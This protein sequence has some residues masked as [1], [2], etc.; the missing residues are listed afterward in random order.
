M[1][2]LEKTIYS[3]YHE[4]IINFKLYSFRKDKNPLRKDI[5]LFDFIKKNDLNDANYNLFF[6]QL[7]TETTN[8]N[9]LDRLKSRLLKEIDNSLIQFHFH[10]SQSQYIYNE[11][12]LYKI[13]SQRN[14]LDL[15][16][17]HLKKAETK[18]IESYDYS[19]LDIIY[20]EFI[21]VSIQYGAIE[22]AIYISKRN[23][24]NVILNDLRALD[25]ALALIIFD[26]KT[27]QNF[28]SINFQ[29]S[30]ALNKAIQQLQKKKLFATQVGFKFKMYQAIS[31]LL[32]SQKD[33]VT[34][35]NYSIKTYHDFIKQKNFSESTHRQKLNILVHIC[36]ALTANNKNKEALVYLEKL[37]NVLSEYNNLFYNQYIFFYYNSLANNYS[38]LNLHKAIDVLNEAKD[39]LAIQQQETQL[40]Y[41]YLNLAGAYY[42]LKE[43]KLALK[44]ILVLIQNPSFKLLNEA[45]KLKVHIHEVILRVELNDLEY[46]NKLIKQ[47][48]KTYRKILKTKEHTED[49]DFLF[50]LSKLILKNQWIVTKKTDEL[51]HLFSKAKYN[52]S[53]TGMVNYKKW[54]N[55]KLK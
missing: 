46:A 49:V 8:K 12:G 20:H 5:Q 36:N 22:P 28:S 17:H 41:I 37:K 39:N 7:Y 1:D 10:Q 4:E 2:N 13:F 24:N 44:N 45:F 6:K 30:D 9:T 31:S 50:L 21:D 54:L 18:A 16:I 26:L 33:F 34:L 40:G 35:E 23:Q 53:N 52:F 42:D 11:I 15:A 19:I 27:S 48:S 55:A 32:I 29:K 43:Y 3:L 38:V 47:I 25:D 14:K 51:Y